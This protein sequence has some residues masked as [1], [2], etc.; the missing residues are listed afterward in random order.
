MKS[1][2]KDGVQYTIIFE[3]SRVCGSSETVLDLSFFSDYRGQQLSLFSHYLFKI[4]STCFSVCYSYDVNV[5]VI[6]LLH[7]FLRIVLIT[8]V[9]TF[10]Y[11]VV[12]K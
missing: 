12:S 7:V 1:I 2:S 8:L 6:L 3:L 4:E 10:E 9:I 5:A 11:W